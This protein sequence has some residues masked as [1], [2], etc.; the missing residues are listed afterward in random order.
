MLANGA[1]GARHLSS[2]EEVHHYIAG[3]AER[4]DQHVG[5]YEMKKEQGE[6]KFVQWKAQLT[7]ANSKYGQIFNHAETVGYLTGVRRYRPHYNVDPIFSIPFCVRHLHG[8]YGGVSGSRCLYSSVLVLMN[9]L[10]LQ[11]LV[12]TVEYGLSVLQGLYGVNALEIA[13]SRKLDRYREDLATMDDGTMERP[14]KNEVVRSWNGLLQSGGAEEREEREV[15]MT[16]MGEQLGELDQILITHFSKCG[17]SFMTSSTSWTGMMPIYIE[18]LRKY[19]DQMA[20]QPG[21][22]RWVKQIRQ[23]L[24]EKVQFVMMDHRA[25]HMAPPMPLMTRTTIALVADTLKDITLALYEVS[26]VSYCII[27]I[28]VW[29]CPHRSSGYD[30]R[31]SVDGSQWT[32][33]DHPR[34]ALNWTQVEYIRLATN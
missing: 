13:E 30:L 9:Y 3:P 23:G 19:A 1:E 18:A 12:T 7:K 25:L 20:Q 21:G 8:T 31:V 27:Y 6:D 33:V 17:Q 24:P 34:W 16:V 2:N 4:M 28:Q 32:Q 10:Y 5:D 11:F 26:C 29:C 15:E 22:T 14:W